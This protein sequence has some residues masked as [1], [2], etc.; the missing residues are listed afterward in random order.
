[1]KNLSDQYGVKSSLRKGKKYDVLEKRIKLP[2]IELENKIH[3]DTF[4]TVVL[5]KMDSNAKQMLHQTQGL[6]QI[7]DGTY[8]CLFQKLPPSI[9]IDNDN[10]IMNTLKL[11]KNNE[12]NTLQKL[13]LN[14]GDTLIGKMIRSTNESKRIALVRKNDNESVHDFLK[15]IKYPCNLVFQRKLTINNGL[16]KGYARRCNETEWKCSQWSPGDTCMFI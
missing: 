1:V 4:I 13:E 11:Q 9:L 3:K 14:D 8:T 2:A 7:C 10:K 5:E 6:I 16:E 15:V 12:I